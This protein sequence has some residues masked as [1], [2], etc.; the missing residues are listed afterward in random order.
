MPWN[1]LAY[2]FGAFRAHPRAYSGQELPLFLVT[3]FSKGERSDLT[4]ADR[5]HLARMTKEL[6]SE[7]RKRVVK[8]ERGER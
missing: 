3:V 2:L 6:V 1:A 5:N 7:Y 4:K 8:V